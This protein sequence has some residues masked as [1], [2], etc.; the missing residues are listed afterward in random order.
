[1]NTPWRDRPWR[2]RSAALVI[3]ALVVACLQWLAPQ[4]LSGVE[5]QAGDLAWR[6]GASAQPERRLVVVDIDEAS[7]REVGPWPWPRSTLAQLALKLGQAGA[8]VQAYDI[9]FSDAKEGD[10]LL[11]DAW[12]RSP[13]VAG[14]LFSI[15]SGVTPRAGELAGALGQTGCPPFAPRSHGFYGTAPVLLG[16]RPAIGHLTPRV[17]ADGVVRKVP[18]LVCQ[19]GRAY[20]SL[21]L[22]ALWR[23]GHEADAGQRLPAPDWHWQRADEGEG[24]WWA[25][26]AWLTSASLPGLKVPLDDRGDLRVPYRLDRKAFASVSA[27]EVLRDGSDLSV[28]K[29]AL[30]LV[31]ATA[32]G[33]GDTVATP[34]A[35]VAA[36]LE[37]HAQTVAAMLDHRL[38]YS[39]RHAGTLAWLAIVGIGLILL[40]LSQRRGSIPAKRLPLAG[41]V[42]A[43][44]GW[45]GASVLLVQADLW[46]PWSAPALFAMLG[47]VSLATAEHALTRAQRER[48]SAHLGAY[49]PGPVA[50]QL[51]VSDPSG[52]V[53]VEQ[54][55]I[56]VLLADIRNFSAFAAH[57]PPQET[58]AVLHAFCCIAVDVVE[59]HGG[60]VENVVGDSVLA[61][62]N[63]YSECADHS[64]QAL[65]AAQE[66]VRAT[67]QLL[68]GTQPTSES[69]PVQPL[70]L[71][72]GVETG[73]AI[74]GSF[75][76]TRRRAHAALG[77]PVSV[78][79]RI[80]QMTLD[81]SIPIL[82]GPNLASSLPAE[83]MEP[84]GEY[85]LEGLGRHYALYAP[86]S[87]GELVPTDPQWVRSATAAADRL[88]EP[89][90]WSHWADSSNPGPLQSG[91]A[92]IHL[93]DA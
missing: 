30:V 7:L 40:V 2:L 56:S 1:M 18:A 65:A 3:A 68:E 9:N 89:S 43:A 85:L 79:S 31:G 36:G 51:M 76:P 61:V 83:A 93:R 53:Q 72:V 37:I 58:A 39:P 4:A 59:Q 55:P 26:H 47:S 60:V 14:Q 44:V 41:V 67:R 25:P 8:V 10:G 16:A 78:A 11:R 22:T 63:A 35:S 84:L 45:L 71:G 90:G 69:S 29:G 28:L 34:H 15:D 24:G 74:V 49:L 13:V 66:L 5:E 88:S 80:Q 19:D 57:R 73:S 48:L 70:A 92:S 81:L 17:E 86:R 50:Q 32:F 46:L 62:W 82:V 52:S 54:R 20:P 27:A 23:A 91:A 12:A 87:W 77:E 33:I 64:Q 21:A 75:G 6:V 38:P 42:L